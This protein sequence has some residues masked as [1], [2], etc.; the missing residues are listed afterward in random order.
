IRQYEPHGRGYYGAIAALIGRDADGGEC[1]E[2]PILIR[3]ADVDLNGNVT[4]TAGARLVRDSDPELE[5]AETWAK[6]SGM[7]S[8][9]GLLDP[10]DH[11]PDVSSFTGQDDVLIA[12]GARNQH[13]S[14]FWLTD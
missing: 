11:A 4:V 13:L 3:T 9:F 14:R 12:L 10:V 8:A 1:A 2:A 6:A 5:T 7:L